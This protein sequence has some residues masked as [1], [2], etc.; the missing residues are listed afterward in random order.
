M[1]LQK[2]TKQ[3]ALSKT[4]RFELVPQLETLN[5]IEKKGL[6]QEDI[7]L[8]EKYKLVKGIID[9]YH[10]S[11]IEQALANAKLSKLEEYRVL[12]S[13]RDKT[14]ADLKDFAKLESD[15]RKEIAKQF[16]KNSDGNISAKF[17]RL[18]KKELIKEDL[19]AFAS[20]AD[21]LELINAFDSF[22]T[23]FEGF[24][25]NRE[26]MYS[27][28]DKSTAIAFRLINQNLPKFIDNMAVFAKLAESPI[29]EQ[30]D[31]IAGDMSPFIQVHTIEEMFNMPY[32]NDVLTQKGIDIYNYVI[33]GYVS[34]DEKTKIK[35][36]N[37]YINLHN[38]QQADKAKRLPK[39]RMLY[40]QI[41]SDRNS[42]SFL[43]KEFA[44]DQQLL[45]G[46]EGFWQELNTTVLAPADKDSLSLLQLLEG[47]KQY[48]ITQIYLRND[49]G[50][51][52]A[53]Q[54]LYGSW[55]VVK[56][57]LT[58]EYLKA[59]SGKAA[60]GSEK[61]E[62]GLEKYLKKPK[63][64]ALA[65]I[66]AAIAAMTSD[67]SLPST[68]TYYA[69][70]QHY[71]A[72]QNLQQLYSQ[73]SDVLN[74]YPQ[75]K[76][77]LN[78]T[79]AVEAIKALLDSIKQ[80]QWYI[81]PLLGSGTEPDK[82]LSFYTHLDKLW[83]TIDQV[84]PLYN[85]VRNYLTRKPYS[86]KKIKLNF[87]NSQLLAGWDDNQ[88]EANSSILL[89]KDGQYFIGIM[90]KSHN[91]IFRKVPSVA[92][93]VCYRQ[94]SYK[95]VSGANKMLP[96]VF[97]SAKRIDDFAPSAEVL[98]VRNTASFTKSGKPQV[99]YE[100]EDF[101]LKSLHTMIDFY[102]ASLAK[103][104]DWQVFNFTFRPTEQYTSIDAFYREFELQ[105]YT[106]SF[107][108]IPASYLEQLV[109]EGK[110]YLFKLHNKDFSP[111]STGTP[112]MHTMY[113]RMLFDPQNL[114]NI[115]YK[116]NG[117][118]EIF[119]R[120]ASI[121]A[122]NTI[123]HPAQQAID[124]K[125][126]NV[127]ALKPASTFQYDIIKDRRFTVDKFQFHV[128]ITM[129]F[130]AAG[131]NIV[132][133]LAYAYIKQNDKQYVIGLDRGE[134]HL[135]YLTLIDCD[136]H[137]VQQMSL[138]DIVSSY[139]NGDVKVNYHNLLDAREG[140]REDA[141]KNWRTIEGIKELKEG[142]LSQVIHVLTK[143]M[144]EYNAVVVLEDLN[145]GF[146]RGRQK[147]EKQVYQKFEK[148]LIDKLNYLVDKKAEPLAEA[149][150]LNAVQLTN[151]FDPKFKGG[152]QNGML[153]YVPA[154][155]T[156]KLDPATGFVNLFNLK[157]EN[158]QQAA[159]F[160]AKFDKIVYNKQQ[161]YY[162][163]HFD[164]SKFTDKATG[165]KTQWVACTHGS[166]ILSFRNPEKNGNWDSKE[167][168]LTEHMTALLHAAKVD[169]HAANLQEVIIANGT[170]EL[171]KSMLDTLKLVMQMRNSIPNSDI[172]Y[173]V[174]P[175]CNSQGVFF[176]SR[177]APTTLPQNADANGAYN[178]ARK[179]L[180]YVQAIQSSEDYKS[181]KLR[182]SNKD[183]LGFAQQG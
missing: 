124:N 153:F 19:P 159:S 50:L 60:I 161:G 91:K 101:S 129:N 95:Q 29:A 15:L 76:N 21:E 71:A 54:K 88:K 182:I 168:N 47:I 84:N 80:L 107:T 120:E 137:I 151:K 96:K 145:S 127:Q 69:N 94:M 3:Y 64:Y 70:V 62:E 51:T 138:N 89:E 117:K 23:Y 59:Y 82:D 39:F 26:N 115:V 147:V 97:F 16:A 169:I 2:F 6:L 149:G 66:D 163:F 5:W 176:D 103:H 86:L 123:T 113:W 122:A 22:T 7:S 27:A 74:A 126:A 155:N 119:Y 93:Q 31:K 52:D 132:S 114:S 34:E 128:P 1:T 78:D 178:I 125:N 77:L 158:T 165:T 42:V 170:K 9:R 20:N 36:L 85:M 179:G 104:A 30:L 105:S 130:G 131:G 38:Q 167:I 143:L 181:C 90:D 58:Q 98:R 57:A 110:L 140:A 72:L 87:K 162:E 172:D 166:R 11:F 13:K 41:L 45:K 55:A 139:A 37:E 177:T 134:R 148:M 183:W 142:Y 35:G 100:R 28:E 180:M 118:A 79:K 61:F 53:S 133:P 136:G 68:S 109:A 99:G 44:D 14:D 17:G 67:E 25:T 75:G 92:G 171:L 121:K 174:S 141:R 63:S 8:A 154:W 18:F 152:V 135:L 108:D 111:Y 146:M 32:Y 83:Q 173:L 144:I 40:K 150:V 156:S 65:E 112:N 81:K 160:F 49:A 43:P 116:L 10:K 102:K 164:Y 33:G 48:D 46:I 73:C 157:Y 24:H 175:V 56:D 4:L 106:V 12:Y